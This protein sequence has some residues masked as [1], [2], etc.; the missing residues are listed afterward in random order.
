MKKEEISW[1]LYDV[2]NSAF[3]LIIMTI[4]MPIFFKEYAAAGL[5]NAEST[6]WLGYASSFSSLVIA[7]TSPVLGAIADYKGKKMRMFLPFFITG[8]IFTFLLVTI[9]PGDWKYCLVIFMVARTAWYGTLVFYDAFLVDVSDEK[10]MD[11]VSSKGYAWGYI[12]SVIPFVICIAII[13]SDKDS[14]KNYMS[15]KIAF[16]ITGI[17]WLVFTLPMLKNVRQKYFIPAGSSPVKDSIKRLVSGFRNL[18]NQGGI[19]LFL[20]AYFFYIDGVDTIITM[21]VAYGIDAKLGTTFLILAFLMIQVLAFPFALVYGKLAEKFT[22]VIMIKAGIIMYIVIT[23][24]SFFLPGI[25]S[26]NGKMIVFCL[27]CFL[28]STSMGGIQALSRSYFGKLIPPERS[29][30]YFGLYNVFGK[31]ASIIGPFMMGL[32]T[33]ITGSSRYGVLCILLLFA[34]GWFLLEKAE[35]V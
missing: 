10:D 13:L 24:I 11:M 31:F 26:Y 30:E 35:K 2:A 7:L 16:V 15:Y 32:A 1:I 5:T 19:Y 23:L 3:V 33:D 14:A 8:I 29:A 28:V 17:W 20:L 21:S 34:A 22:A 6:A 12:G 25:E 4:L 9:G 27:L 18:K